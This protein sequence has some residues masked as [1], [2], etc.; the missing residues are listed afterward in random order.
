MVWSPG[1]GSWRCLRP[2]L[3][4]LG[5]R[6]RVSYLSL[7]RTGPCVRMTVMQGI[8]SCMPTLHVRRVELTRLIYRVATCVVVMTHSTLR[9]AGN[10]R[11]VVAFDI[12]GL[13][14]VALPI[15]L[16][17]MTLA[18]PHG[19]GWVLLL[20]S[21]SW[22][23]DGGAYFIGGR[24]GRHKCCPSVSPGKSWEGVFAELGWTILTA[25]FIRWL[26]SSY[27]IECIDLPMLSKLDCI[28]MGSVFT[29]GGVA[30]DLCESMLKRL[31]GFKDSG[32]FFP[33]HGGILDRF[34]GMFF[35]AILLNMRLLF[36]PMS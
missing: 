24:F 30:G 17:N 18:M 1:G 13:L 20:I 6:C 21:C 9:R 2:K 28:V 14:Y 27:A 31:T 19:Q 5:R 7:T 34:D 23:G 35:T 26:R 15:S 10:V 25:L 22:I 11:K 4:P 3:P 29:V 33:G 8:N 16:C 32:E 12:M 36:W